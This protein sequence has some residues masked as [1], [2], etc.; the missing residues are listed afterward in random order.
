MNR[1]ADAL[2]QRSSLLAMLQTEITGFESLKEMYPQD[3]DFAVIWRDCFDG[4][5]MGN[6]HIID[7][8]LF[9]GNQMSVPKTSLR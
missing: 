3:E 8:Y 5:R 7:G 6:F 2:S 4:N 9:K 1:V